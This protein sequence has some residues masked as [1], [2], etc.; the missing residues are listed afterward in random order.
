M[1]SYR[2]AELCVES[3]VEVGER[4]GVGLVETVLEP[5]PVP[6]RQPATM[7]MLVDQRHGGDVIRQRCHRHTLQAIRNL[8]ARCSRLRWAYCSCSKRRTA[9]TTSTAGSPRMARS[10]FELSSAA[11]VCACELVSGTMPARLRS[12]SD[13]AAGSTLVSGG[14]TAFS[15]I[16]SSANP[17][18]AAVAKYGLADASTTLT[19]TLPPTGLPGPPTMKR[20][21]ASRF[22]VP[23]QAYAPAQL[24]ECNRS[25]DTIDPHRMPCA[26]GKPLSTPASAFSPLLVIPRM[27][28]PSANSGPAELVSEKCWWAPHPTSPTNGAG[29]RL[30]R[31]P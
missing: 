1:G 12:E 10:R 17:R 29:D 18:I 8:S 7:H 20:S 14:S 30:T 31:S 4:F 27:P 9:I 5:A 6:R 28:A 13:S 23:Q 15:L 19:S 2:E 22:S 26:S 16:P 21:A 24:P 3:G 11:M 25:P